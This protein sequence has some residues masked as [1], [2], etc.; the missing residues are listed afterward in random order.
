V[1]QL[2]LKFTVAGYIVRERR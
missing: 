2:T 1:Y